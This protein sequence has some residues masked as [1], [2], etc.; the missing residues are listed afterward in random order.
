MKFRIVFCIFAL[1]CFG[2]VPAFACSPTPTPFDMTPIP[3]L[4]IMD[5][6]QNAPI[7]FIGMVVDDGEYINSELRYQL[8]IETYLKGSG[9]DTAYIVGYGGG[10]S[11]QPYIYRDSRLIFFVNSHMNSAGI[12]VY[13]LITDYEPTDAHIAAVTSITGQ[14]IPAQAL[15][16][17]IQMTRI[18]ENG[19][20][21]WL[22]IPLSIVAA[23][24][25]LIAVALS[26]RLR[27]RRKSKAKREELL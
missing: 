18:A 19:D 17:D 13:Y 12:P 6:T 16:L 10:G 26:R 4:T 24:L 20:L 14:S 5:F 1:F 22:Y 8:R 27:N 2:A 21:N 15:P 3:P 11:C 9:Y 7:I 23:L 25:G